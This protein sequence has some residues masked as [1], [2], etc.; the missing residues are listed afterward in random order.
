MAAMFPCASITGAPKARTMQI[1][2]ALESTPR[3]LYTGCIGFLAP[4]RQAQFSVAIRTVVIDRQAH[5]AE[6]GVGGGIVWES[7]AAS[8]YDECLTKARVLAESRPHVTLL[9]TI[10]WEPTSGYFLLD[11]H[12]DRLLESAAYFDVSIDV[13]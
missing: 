3:G 6:Y 7:E 13:Q 5:L 4:G 10:L 1:I 2:A 12:L 9:E 11:R 8:E